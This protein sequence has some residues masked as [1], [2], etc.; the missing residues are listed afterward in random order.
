MKKEH[1]INIVRTIIIIGFT[2]SVLFHYVLSHYN[3]LNYYPFNTFLFNPADKF[4]DFF[5]IY[6]AAVLLNPYAFFVSV[7]FPFTFIIMYLF[8]MIS[9][10]YAFSLFLLIFIAYF[11]YYI[12]KNIND[13]G[14]SDIANKILNVFVFS[15]MAYPFL[16]NID[17]GN[18]EC[19]I[20]VFLALFIYFYQKKQVYI[21]AIFLSLAASMK[22][23]PWIFAVLL[24]SD[25]KYKSIFIS[26][27]L[28]VLLTLVSAAAFQGGISGSFAGLLNNLNKFNQGYLMHYTGLQHNLSLYGVAYL[29]L[30][31]NIFHLI[32]PLFEFI[33]RNYFIVA[34]IM[35]GSV[36][37]YIMFVNERALWKKSALL[38]F[39]ILLLPPVS[40]DYKLIHLFIPLMLFFN[41]DEKS[42][43][44]NFVYSLLFGL[45]LIPKDYY[46]IAD[47]ISIAVILNPAIMLAMIFLIISSG[48][49]SQSKRTIEAKT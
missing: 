36:M 14:S 45:L 24:L 31:S 15:F 46:I 20:F 13:H 2:L 42:N 29:L 23:Y 17:R 32:N 39:L 21:G 37:A 18:M 41:C 4:N 48:L 10:N 44:F 26:I 16:F 40:F 5:N 28:V 25:K 6:H 49:K 8:T 9:A 11:I 38:V 22:L 12:H 27:A 1:K 43:K 35:L 3:G 19:L 33:L 30:Q 34:G 7:Y 47:D